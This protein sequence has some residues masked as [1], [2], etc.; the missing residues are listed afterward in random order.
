MAPGLALVLLAS[1]LLPPA[2][3]QQ[4]SG[5]CSEGFAAWVKRSE[6]SIKTQPKRGAQP[7]GPAKEACVP[8]EGVRKSLQRALAAVKRKCQGTEAASNDVVATLPL[9]EINVDAVANMPVCAAAHVAGNRPGANV[10]PQECLTLEFHD[11]V[12]W[13]NNA[14]CGGQKIIAV[15]EIK[16]TSGI[17]KCRGHIVTKT[18]KLG[19]TRPILNYECVQNERDCSVK[20]VKAIFP[21]CAW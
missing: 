9:V 18:T 12:H 3:A 10:Q 5:P 16:L 15:V 2:T 8:N 14:N 4:G 17:L 1:P 13:L 11:G 21:Y 6:E 7:G 20:S 19:T